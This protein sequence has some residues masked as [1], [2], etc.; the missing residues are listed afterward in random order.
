[1]KSREGLIRLKRFQADEKRR[2]VAQIEAT[3]AEFE[4]MA[5]DLSD[6]VAA[7]E[8]RSGIRDTGHFAYPT[9]AKAAASRR[10]NLL[11]SANGMRDRLA[12]A[13][14]EYAVAAEELAKLIALAERDM[15]QERMSG[16]ES[17]SAPRSA[18]F[19][20]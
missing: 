2:Q 18:A 5:K 4:R 8:Q 11:A 6:Q 16:G 10:D 13:Q 15:A 14:A 19:A 7:E 9:L 3:I 17:S 1:M 20:R 12:A